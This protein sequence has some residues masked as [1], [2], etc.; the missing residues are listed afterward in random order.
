MTSTSSNLLTIL[1]PIIRLQVLMMH[2][3]I[4]LQVEFDATA[5]NNLQTNHLLSSLII[6]LM[7]P[8]IHLSGHFL[9]TQLKCHNSAI[10]I[11]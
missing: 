1:D 3:S 10:Q 7:Y 5:S 11:L 4:I 8:T 2:L 9:V 6:M